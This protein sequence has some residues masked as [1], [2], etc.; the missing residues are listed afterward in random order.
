MI[1]QDNSFS[2]IEARSVIFAEY[3]NEADGA[4]PKTFRF[5]SNLFEGIK[6]KQA[7]AAIFIKDTPPS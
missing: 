5:A 7:G 3:F 2:N 4:T 6:G 1:A